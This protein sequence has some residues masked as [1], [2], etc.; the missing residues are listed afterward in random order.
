MVVASFPDLFATRSAGV[1]LHIS[2]LP[3]G[4]GVGD[5]GASALAFVDWMVQA[6]LNKWQMLPLVPAGAG[7]SPYSS[8]ASLAGNVQ[9]I[10]LQQLVVLGLLSASDLQNAP[11]NGPQVDFE[12]VGKFK[13]HALRRAFSTYKE[14]SFPQLAQVFE[15]FRSDADWANEAALYA[16]LKNKHG[17]AWRNWPKQLQ[18]PTR[19]VLSALFQEHASEVEEECFFQFLFE[20][21]WQKLRNYANRQGVA[22]VGDIPIYVDLDS[23]DV[24]LNQELFELDDEGQPKQVS[25]VPPDNFSASGQLWGHPVYKWE[26]HEE[27]GFAWWRRRLRR[28]VDQTDVVRID[29]F[30]GFSAYWSVPFG[31][32][33]ATTG[34]WVEGPGLKLF[35]ALRQ[36]FPDGLPVIAEDLGDIDEAVLQLKKNA[37]L[38]GMCVLQFGFSANEDAVHHPKNHPEFSVAYTGTHDNE[39]TV[40]WRQSLSEES[41]LALSAFFAHENLSDESF[42]WK[43]IELLFSSPSRWA[44]VPLQDFLALG[45]EARM[46]FP[47]TTS[48]NWS[49]RASG[50]SLSIELA[51]QI[52][53]YLQAEASGRWQMPVP[54][55]RK[56]SQS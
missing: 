8:W 11:S 47:S 32:P 34:R 51:A 49:W 25:G 42:A 36:D 46:N 27:E 41:H 52:R 39:T 21:Q 40:Q 55:Q 5:L 30:R 37:G 6:G 18:K 48:G 12:A 2:S 28:C 53:G 19:E 24:W 44:I 35:E 7:H 29:H 1:L 3:G 9:M 54:A 50:E 31:S 26:A 56:T 23:A 10:D 13:N 4:H 20:T 38:P 15:R 22:L 45:K 14:K 17:S 33:D 43:F 16:V